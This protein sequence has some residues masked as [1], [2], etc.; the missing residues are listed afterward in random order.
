M[1]DLF[2]LPAGTALHPANGVRKA[3][4][5][6]LHGAGAPVQSAFFQQLVPLLCARGLEVLT[7]NFVYMQ[8]TLAGQRKVA[9]KAE[10]LLPELESIIAA[11]PTDLPLLLA[12]KSMGG[13]LLS[14]YL[15][16]QPAAVVKTG[17]VFGYPLC[18][19]A[20]AKEQDKASAV[21]RQRSQHF[22]SL[23]RPLLICQGSRDAF[24]SPA[25]VQQW[26]AGP[27]SLMEIALADHDFKQSR[28]R[29]DAI[30]L[31]AAAL[32]GV[33]AGSL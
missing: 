5:L 17:M 19:P 3:R 23:K 26:L 8:Q 18:P 13:R 12:G 14:L 24:G 4:V 2:A 9:P 16:A 6:L 21:C 7:Y 29:S 28:G 27:V 31:L 33:L 30:A 10:K 22:A 32:D 20:K 11:L 25:L 1:P 15:A